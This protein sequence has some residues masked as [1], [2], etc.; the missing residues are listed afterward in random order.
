MEKEK[1][2]ETELKSNKPIICPSCGGEL[3][4]AYVYYTPQKIEVGTDGTKIVRELDF[5]KI[6]LGC[7]KCEEESEWKKKN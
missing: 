7:S 4:K 6:T 5:T 2:R 1:R 3:D